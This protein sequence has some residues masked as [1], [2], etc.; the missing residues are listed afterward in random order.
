MNKNLEFLRLSWCASMLPY[1]LNG[2]MS[3]YGFKPLFPDMPMLY[4]S[5]G[6]IITILYSL[7]LIRYIRSIN[8]EI[9]KNNK[10]KGTI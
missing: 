8:E 9:I 1:Y 4:L 7:D 3:D 2:L 5:L 6:T 10:N